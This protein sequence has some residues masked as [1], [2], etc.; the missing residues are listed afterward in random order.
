MTG[1][2]ID[3]SKVDLSG[4]TPL[5]LLPVL[6]AVISSTTGGIIA[7]VLTDPQH[8]FWTLIISYVLWGIGVPLALMVLVLYFHRLMVHEML[9]KQV[10]VSA[11]LPIGPFGLAG[12]S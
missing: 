12:F 9:E 8:Q 11:F 7:P 10:I 1:R 2:S 3:A 5:W 6:P 4:M